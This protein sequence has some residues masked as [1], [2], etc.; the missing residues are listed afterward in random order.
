MVIAYLE[1][2]RDKY[3]VERVNLSKELDDI[4]KLQKENEE[5]IKVL[6][7]NEDPH[8]ESFSPREVNTF[9]KR[10]IEELLEN[11]NKLENEME[12]ISDKLQKVDNELEEIRDVIKV[13]REKYV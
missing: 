7:A 3:Y 2:I 8:F 12:N 4:L 13:A 6:K 5:I 10:K 1:K 9:N 11:Q